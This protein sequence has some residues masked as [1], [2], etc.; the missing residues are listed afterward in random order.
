MSA[1]PVQ[2]S[3]AE[4]MGFDDRKFQL[5]Y[6]TAGTRYSKAQRTLME[7]GGRERRFQPMVCT[8][9]NFVEQ[10]FVT[11]TTYGHIDVDPAY[12]RGQTG[13]VTKIE[14]AL[15]AGGTMPGLPT[16]ARRPW[17]KE[18]KQ[19]L[20]IVDGHQRISAAMRVGL[21]FM[22]L[23]FES[24]SLDAEKTAFVVL[25]DRKGLSPS[26]IVKDWTGP[27]RAVL[28]TAFSGPLKQCVSFAG[29]RG[30]V[31]ASVFA[32]GLAAAFCG[33]TQ[34]GSAGGSIHGYLNRLDY[35]VGRE[36]KGPPRSGARRSDAWC[37]PTSW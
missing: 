9:F 1:V 30:K 10:L 26:L 3:E 19:K 36:P 17:S 28:E 37:S 33:G 29:T 22:A 13:M 5:P 18:D 15:R 32:K 27:C 11:P 31:Q 23:V 14:L 20:Y 4:I 25:Q 6:K 35:Y 24:E 7:R 12:Q 34:P 8:G 16:L 2:K 21:S